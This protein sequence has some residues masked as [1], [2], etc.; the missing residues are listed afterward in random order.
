MTAW[1]EAEIP[2]YF[3]AN[4]EL[5]GLFH[6]PAAP[7]TKAVLLCP[8]LGQEQIRCHRIYRQLAHSLVAAGISTLRFDYYGT[9]DSA[10]I[11]DEVDWDRCIADTVV[12]AN[13]L[14]QR[15]GAECI[16][17]F[18]ARLGGSIAIAATAADFAG[19]V[20]WDPIL[21]G[22]AYVT[23]LDAMQAELAQDTQ[24]FIKPRQAVD[25]AA[26]WLGFA[27]SD[28]L[29]H[30]LVEL[31]LEPPGAPMLV[32]NT[33]VAPAAGLQ[34]IVQG[35]AMI[36]TLQPPTPWDDLARLE[37]AILLHP[38]IQTVTTHLQETA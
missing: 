5:F 12:A 27:A 26:Q 7:A 9:G 28:R 34:R 3:G 24:R 33:L 31:R 21:D 23:R 2:F 13:E 4:G 36:R 30:Q 32:L 29:R 14:R 15:S 20:V 37:H 1:V 19:L 17:A 16:A 10:G 18:G 6:A 25:A 38:L 22:D 35:E 11:S 8:P